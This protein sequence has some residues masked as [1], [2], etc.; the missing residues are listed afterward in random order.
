MDKAPVLL[1]S[2]KKKKT[3]QSKSSSKKAA[4]EVLSIGPQ[5]PPGYVLPVD[6][7]EPEVIPTMAKEVKSTTLNHQQVAVQK[8][9]SETPTVPTKTDVDVKRDVPVTIESEKQKISA[10]QR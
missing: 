6:N 2:S 4:K 8:P 1:H 7:K 5:L 10:L 3:D 9:Q